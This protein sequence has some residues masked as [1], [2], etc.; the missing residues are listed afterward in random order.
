M[1]ATHRFGDSLRAK[2]VE[3]ERDALVCLENENKSADPSRASENKCLLIST[4]GHQAGTRL[5]A[6]G[7]MEERASRES[8]PWLGLCRLG[9]VLSVKKRA[10]RRL[11]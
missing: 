2:V 7:T 11:I 8:W 10:S 9:I 6:N 4:R 3:T 5:F 1:A